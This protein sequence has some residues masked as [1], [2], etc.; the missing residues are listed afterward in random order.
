MHTQAHWL[1]KS[2]LQRK[3]LFSLNVGFKHL[4]QSTNGKEGTLTVIHRSYSACTLTWKWVWNYRLWIAGGKLGWMT[5]IRKICLHADTIFQQWTQTDEEVKNGH[6][7]CVKIGSRLPDCASRFPFVIRCSCSTLKTYLYFL[8][9]YTKKSWIGCGTISV[10]VHI[11]TEV[12]PTNYTV[13]HGK[14]EMLWM[15]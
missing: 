1:N 9:C 7:F 11:V 6:I 4:A 15:T 8:P 2:H 14:Q 12:R 3:W 10:I 13:F 5:L